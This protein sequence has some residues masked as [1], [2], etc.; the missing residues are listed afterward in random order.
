MG[1]WSNIEVANSRSHTVSDRWGEQRLTLQYVLRWVP[2]NN[3]D[4]FPGEGFVDKNFGPLDTEHHGA[5]GLAGIR[6]NV[7]IDRP[8]IGG[9]GVKLEGRHDRIGVAKLDRVGDPLGDLGGRRRVAA[10][11]VETEE[12]RVQILE[13]GLPLPVVEIPGIV[14]GV[15]RS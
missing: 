1:T 8:A 10:A 14:A 2:T 6:L 9:I 13:V 3:T 4:P 15:R 11:P 5:V 7:A 12:Q